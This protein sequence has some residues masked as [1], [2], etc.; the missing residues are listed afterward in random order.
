M[1]IEMRSSMMFLVIRCHLHQCH[2]MPND[3][4]YGTI[5]FLDQDNQNEE[6]HDFF[7]H[8]MP[9]VLASV[10]CDA[11]NVISHTIAFLISRQSNWGASW[12]FVMWCHWHQCHMKPTV[13]SMAPLHSLGQ[14]NLTEVQHDIFGH[15]IPLV[16]VSASCDVNAISNS[17]TALLRQWWSQWV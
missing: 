4:V 15:A 12:L 17:F 2:L 10:S 9:L 1:T 14:D 13:S 7:G 3:T 6:Q 8:V 5:H 11:D 16:L